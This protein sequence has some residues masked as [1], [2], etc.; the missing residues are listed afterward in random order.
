MARNKGGTLAGKTAALGFDIGGSFVKYGLIDEHG[1]VLF[2]SRTP[3]VLTRGASSLLGVLQRLAKESAH[4]CAA[5][6]LTLRAMG[7]GS[8]GTVDARTGIVT[9]QS[10]NLPGWVDVELRSPFARFGVPVAVDNDANCSAYA[11]YRFGAGKGFR[12]VI[13]IT[14]GTG[15]GSGI[16]LDGELFHGSHYAGAELGHVSIHADGPRCGCGN[17]GCLE[18]YASA[19]AILTQARQLAQSHPA[20]ALAKVRFN[21]GGDTPLAGVFRAARHGDKAAMHLLKQVADDLAVGL[22]GIVNAFDPQILVIGGG[23]ADADPEFVT[24][25]ARRARRLTFQSWTRR[26]RI[27]RARLGN[28]AGFVGAAALGVRLA[29]AACV[30]P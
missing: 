8:P 7:I 26:L 15:I 3:T 19:P 23:V 24:R 17:R 2:S 1:R 22:A 27:R 30:K 20:S 18:L 13:A 4:R 11:E 29:E 5:R 12:D 9:G 6:G 28:Q 21:R 14:L 16:V 10:P 25:V